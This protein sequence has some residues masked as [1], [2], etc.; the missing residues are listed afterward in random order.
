MNTVS[1]E[2]IERKVDQGV[3]VQDS[4]KTKIQLRCEILSNAR[5]MLMLLDRGGRLYVVGACQIL[6]LAKE[7]VQDQ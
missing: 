6:V 3:A 2:E 7:L 5:P 1:V 4:R